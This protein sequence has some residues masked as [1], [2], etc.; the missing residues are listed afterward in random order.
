MPS[1]NR[2]PMRP[3]PIP[4]PLVARPAPTAAANSDHAPAYSREKEP[5]ACKSANMCIVDALRSVDL[6]VAPR[7]P[8]C[9]AAA[10]HRGPGPNELP[11]IPRPGTHLQPEHLLQEYNTC[12]R[13]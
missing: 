13:I 12:E 7:R 3:M 8:N 1:A 10:R 6:T 4:A 5:A 9:T 11:R 2:P